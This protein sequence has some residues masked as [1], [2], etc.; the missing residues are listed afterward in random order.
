MPDEP[1]KSY[2]TGPPD[3]PVKPPEPIPPWRVALGIVLIALG[4]FAIGCGTVAMMIAS[5]RHES[6]MLALPPFMGG[7]GFIAIGRQLLQR[8]KRH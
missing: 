2:W 4:V 1:S 8:K 6:F 5:F 7:A 3:E